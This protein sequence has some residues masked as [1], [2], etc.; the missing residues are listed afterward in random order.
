MIGRIL[1]D[2]RVQKLILVKTW[3]VEV[4][5]NDVDQIE[6]SY[7]DSLFLDTKWFKT[8]IVMLCILSLK[9]KTNLFVYNFFLK[10]F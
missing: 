8:M 2:L 10:K 4:G 6:S 9:V 5:F 1:V 7:F 3:M